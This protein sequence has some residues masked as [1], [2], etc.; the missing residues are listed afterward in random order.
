MATCTDRA[1]HERPLGARARRVRP[2]VTASLLALSICFVPSPLVSDAHAAEAL[3]LARP[4][5][6]ALAVAVPA[7][8][9]LP[10]PEPVVPE[11]VVPERVVP[12]RVVPGRV[13]KDDP[14]AGH[15]SPAAARR[16]PRMSYAA[17]TPNRADLKSGAGRPDPDRIALG[18]LRLP[19]QGWLQCLDD[20]EP[21]CQF[22][23]V[24]LSDRHWRD[25]DRAQAINTR[26]SHV[27]DEDEDW[28]APDNAYTDVS[29]APVGDCEDSALAKL[30]YLRGQ[31]WPEE[32]LRI[33]VGRRDGISH[34]ALLVRTTLCDMIL[35]NEGPV[36][37]ASKSRFRVEKINVGPFWRDARS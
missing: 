8:L 21:G 17:R 1:C 2:T 27:S 15:E 5:T 26:W 35:D 11:R 32:A 16:E 13:V 22:G 19:P 20:G 34:A 37:C 7:A 14:A 23:A 10:R 18:D 6:V 4:E 31:G 33:A 30:A 9:P 36:Q 24:E 28:R 3:P 12:E 25:L 29:V